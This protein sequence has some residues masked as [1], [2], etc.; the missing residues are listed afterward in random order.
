MEAFT[1]KI[2]I[3]NFCEEDI[4]SPKGNHKRFG[5]ITKISWKDKFDS[6]ESES[7]SIEVCSQSMY[8]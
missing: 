6:I 7:E 3:P 5:Q 1:P 4:V 8:N 2:N